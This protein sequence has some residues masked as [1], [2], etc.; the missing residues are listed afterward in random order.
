MVWPGA[1][2]RASKDEGVPSFQGFNVAIEQL[3]ELQ[4]MVWVARER[5]SLE[6]GGAGGTEV[7]PGSARPSR[8]TGRSS[9][10]DSEWSGSQGRGAVWKTDRG[11][12][13][14]RRQSPAHKA[15]GCYRTAVC[16]A[17]RAHE[18][19]SKTDESCLARPGRLRSAEIS[20]FLL[21]APTH[22]IALLHATKH[23]LPMV[24]EWMTVEVDH[25]EGLCALGEGDGISGS[26]RGGTHST[27]T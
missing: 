11:T 5:L 1:G 27:L 10:G 2:D 12:R 4:G 22:S 6:Q 18:D 8:G 9:E 15:R 14:S 3:V 26:C 21:T 13:S 17:H 19:V 16:V 20:I 24:S 7:Q 25:L 23:L